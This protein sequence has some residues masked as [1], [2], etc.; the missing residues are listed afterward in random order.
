MV[1]M[2]I[3]YEGALRCVVRHEPS[4]EAF[5][6]D[7]PVDNHGRGESPSPTDLCAAALGSCIATVI[8][9]Q[10]EKRGVEL[11]GMRI[12]VSKT[13]S[14]YLPR[15]IAKLT[16]EI[17]IPVKLEAKDRL[18]VETAAKNCPVHHSLSSEIEKP[19]IFHWR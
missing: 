8:G 12:E 1:K 14:K 17:W 5:K 15:R 11:K 18:R 13:M 10:M 7:A 2:M 9:I 16:T 4:G 19:I 3:D 6:T